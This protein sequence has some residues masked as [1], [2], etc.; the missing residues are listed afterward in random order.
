MNAH[1]RYPDEKGFEST[2]HPARGQPLARVRSCRT[3]CRQR[4]QALLEVTMSALLVL[5]PI[6]IFGWV[7]YAYGQARTTALNA[8]RYAAWERTVWREAATGAGGANRVVRS[9]EVIEDHMV[10][11]FFGRPDARI[12]SIYPSGERSGNADVP[13][14]FSLHN[15]DKVID[16]ERS[17]DAAGDGQAARPT[18]RLGKDG[19]TISRTAGVYNTIANFTRGGARL[20][21]GGLHVAEV[22]VKLNAVRNVRVLDELNLTITQRAAA[23]GDTWSAGGKAHEEDI[24]QP[25]VPLGALTNIMGNFMGFLEKLGGLTPFSEFKPGCVR[26]DVVPKDMLPSGSSQT[27]VRCN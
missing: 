20:E 17:A 27:G 3:L 4:G 19:M 8:A 22:D 11:R 5:I 14:F 16:V 1:R 10:E 2:R 23:V 6:F 26:G 12:Q 7:L 25:L 18:L 21:D 13:S 24:V 9:K 15:R